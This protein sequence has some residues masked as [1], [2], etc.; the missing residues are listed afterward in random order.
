LRERKTKNKNGAF[1]ASEESRIK[2]RDDG[3]QNS[4]QLK[5]SR[6]PTTA[7]HRSF[8]TQHPRDLE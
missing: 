8:Q 1:E 2:A 4:S 3:T 6:C 7:C 5:G